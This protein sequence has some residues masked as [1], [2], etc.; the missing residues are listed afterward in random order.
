MLRRTLSLIAILAIS[1]IAVGCTIT[2]WHLGG[3]SD[4][5]G[6][7][8][9]GNGKYT[10]SEEY[11]AENIAF[12]WECTEGCSSDTQYG[13]FAPY[14]AVF[15]AEDLGDHAL[16]YFWKFPNNKTARGPSVEHSFPSPGDK[17]V[18]L[19]IIPRGSEKEF[20]IKETL[21]IQKS[22]K[23]LVY[24][25]FRPG[26]ICDVGIWI[27]QDPGNPGGFVLG[28]W[29]EWNL[30]DGQEGYAIQYDIQFVRGLKNFSGWHY[31]PI[32]TTDKEG[33]RA[34]LMLPGAKRDIPEMRLDGTRHDAIEMIVPT[35]KCFSDIS[36][37]TEH[38]WGYPVSITIP[39]P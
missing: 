8:G 37:F 33:R 28:G 19:S 5:G 15:T 26:T 9:N 39:K 25:D 38:D 11:V 2:P 7:D 27:A 31:S 17:D 6:S 13:G 24:E 22:P 30:E 35:A 14:T 23:I 32:N 21:V 4:N 34:L 10:E 18:I 12:T 1:L 20:Q 16:A 36:T 29:I 3:G